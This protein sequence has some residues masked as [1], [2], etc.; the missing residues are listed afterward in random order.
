MMKGRFFETIFK[1]SLK[2]L[3]SSDGGVT[4]SL[5]VAN[6]VRRTMAQILPNMAPIILKPITSLE[7]SAMIGFAAPAVANVP[8]IAHDMRMPVRVER[9]FPSIVILAV[10]APYGTVTKEY[11]AENKRKVTRA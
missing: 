1:S 3:C 8:R 7:N 11:S 5:T 6:V 4:R 2:D 10:K 9:S